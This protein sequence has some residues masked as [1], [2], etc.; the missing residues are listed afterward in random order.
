M[1]LPK[2][3]LSLGLVITMLI[4]S[5]PKQSYALNSVDEIEVSTIYE[6]AG[7][8]ADK[9]SYDTAIL[10][11]LNDSIADG[12][13]ASGLSGTLNA[14][15]L[16]SENSSI[17]NETMKRLSKVK[18]VYLIGGIKS[19]SKSVENTLMSKGFNVK[20]IDGDDRIKTSYNVAKEI[21]SKQKVNTVMLTNAY[22]G[23]P[24]AISIASVA[25]RDKA[26]II[27]TD[28]KSI[29]FSTNEVKS[30]AIGGTSTMND[31]LVKNTNSTR[32]GGLTDLIQIK[33]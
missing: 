11:N 8:I 14:P 26:A 15:L 25:A 12:L 20:R 28:G 27:L 22:K 13:S 21:N 16:L 23:E 18:T 1:K 33:K 19:I 32:L 2:K 31:T 4:I 7:L 24:D 3:L 17:P 10:V 5:F 29:P 30:Y 6:T 9:Q